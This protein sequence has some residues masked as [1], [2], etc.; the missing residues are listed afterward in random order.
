MKKDYRLIDLNTWAG[1]RFDE[2]MEFIDREK[3]ETD[4]FCFQEVTST[5][6]NRTETRG[7]RANLYQDFILRLKGFDHQFEYA[8][9]QY[10]N[11]GKVDFEFGY[12]QATF[13]KKSLEVTHQSSLFV[14]GEDSRDVVLHGDWWDSPRNV[15]L[16]D[17][18]LGKEQIRIA[19]FH[20]LWVPG[21]K[22]D[23]PARLKQAENLIKVFEDKNPTILVG[24]FNLD[25]TNDSLRIIEEGR[26]NLIKE[27]GITS[28]RSSFYTR[29]ERYADYAIVTNDIEIKKF[30]V[31]TDEVS[32]HL[33]LEIIFSV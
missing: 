8:A 20:G 16:T 24:D 13:W 5:S 4:I 19:N 9:E 18:E 33:P 30:R 11:V 3:D 26:H 21:F 32:D 2:L 15:L 6:T 17:F 7:V 28:T 25:I 22:S 23:S 14:H 31:M 27:S 1:T 29:E 10:D 12:G